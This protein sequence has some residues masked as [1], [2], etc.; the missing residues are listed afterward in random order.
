MKPRRSIQNPQ[1]EL[2]RVELVN[3]IDTGHPL[4]VLGGKINW[5]V[6]DEQL[7]AT[8][9]Q[10]VG[11]P[12][13]NTRLM[14]ALHYLKYQYNLSDEAVVARWVEE[15]TMGSGC[16]FHIDFVRLICIVL[17]WP[18]SYASNTPGRSTM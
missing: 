15:Q 10:A 7:G 12:G 8:Y 5:T 17:S 4:V 11:A 14:V 16:P 3:I 6:F 1:R 18:E 2:G 9:N 13:I